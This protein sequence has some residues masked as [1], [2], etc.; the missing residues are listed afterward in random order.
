MPSSERLRRP[1]A[2]ARRGLLLW[3]SLV[4]AA[5]SAPAPSQ[6]ATLA[7]A[8]VDTGAAPAPEAAAT[9][10]ALRRGVESGPLFAALATSS[11]V[12]SCRVGHDAG[13]IDLAYRFGDGGWLHVKR[14]ARIEY[15]AQEARFA[16][17]LAEPP[18]AVLA[19]AEKA[20][21]GAQG[22]GIDWAQPETRA[23]EA[24]FSA[25]ETVF[26]GDVCNCQASVR[27]DAAGRVVGLALRSTC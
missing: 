2:V 15:T 24:G 25:T 23:G 4:L 3:A 26:R 10:A 8:C 11:G 27:R 21:F 22:C 7:L 6:V 17:P 18:A 9:L 5:C 16:T 12:A 14:D 19:R 1:P 13:A 20:A